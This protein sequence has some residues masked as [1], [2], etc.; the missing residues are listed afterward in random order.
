MP[1]ELV[2]A[3]TCDEWTDPRDTARSLERELALVTSERVELAE[4]VGV[5]EAAHAE[6]RGLLAAQRVEV[7]VDQ[8]R[9]PRKRP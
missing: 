4:R 9:R 7:N 8:R 6:A 2:A 1:D 3:L 5:L